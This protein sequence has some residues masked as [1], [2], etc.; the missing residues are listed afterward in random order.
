VNV[1]VAELDGFKH[2]GIPLL[3]DARV[4]LEELLE[5]LEG[6][7]VADD[8]GSRI[9][10]LKREWEAE[11]DRVYGL[12]HSPLL[13]QGEVI[14][15]LN[16]FTA[17]TD[18]VVNA[19]GSAP[20][21]LHKLW[22][23]RDPKGYHLEYGYS[24]MGYEIPGALGVKLAAPEREVYVIIGDGSYLM[25]SSDLAT[26][27]QEGI[28]LTVLLIENHGFASIGAL[29]TA[30]GSG[31]FGTERRMRGPDGT[32]SGPPLAIDFAAN[33][34]SLGARAIRAH[35]RKSLE[36][37]LAAARAGDRTTVIVVETD[38]E[39]RVGGTD[40]WWDVAVAEVSEQESVRKARG[41][42]DTARRR[43]R[44]FFGEKP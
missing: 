30:L 24:C 1:N 39:Q 15:V 2:D 7:R 35:D 19:A 28:K 37:A 16:G 42:Y 14:G 12:A 17:P 9:S 27:V 23:T 43:Q 22:R 38:R 36:E 32:L 4:T 18:V 25:L 34:E 5:A 11:V 3:G 13:S 8:Y 6:Y 41:E 21:D 40:A 44:W 10:R 26:A 20:G 29:S 33:A 31:G